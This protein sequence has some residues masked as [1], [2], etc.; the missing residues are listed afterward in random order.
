MA[1]DVSIREY[2][3]WRRKY[4]TIAKTGTILE[5]KLAAQ[6]FRDHFDLGHLKGWQIFALLGDAEDFIELLS[7]MVQE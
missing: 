3:E 1:N 6:A 2:L 4:K 7:M 5:C